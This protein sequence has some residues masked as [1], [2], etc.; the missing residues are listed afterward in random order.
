VDGEEGGMADTGGG[1]AGS[2]LTPEHM[3]EILGAFGAGPLLTCARGKKQP[4]PTWTRLNKESG[5]GGAQA[6]RRRADSPAATINNPADAGVGIT[7]YSTPV[8]TM[9]ASPELP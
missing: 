1:V 3:G 2:V 4:C 5:S 9:P 8:G 7:V 6:R